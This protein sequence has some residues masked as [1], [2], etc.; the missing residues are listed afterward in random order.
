MMFTTRPHDIYAHVSKRGGATSEKDADDNNEWSQTLME[1]MNSKSSS[2]LSHVMRYYTCT[3]PR[4]HVQLHSLSLLTNTNNKQPYIHVMVALRSVLVAIMTSSAS[5][6]RAF[7]SHLTQQQQPALQS[8]VR[9]NIIKGSPT[10]RNHQALSSSTSEEDGTS[11]SATLPP[12]RRSFLFLAAVMAGGA[13]WQCDPLVTEAAQT[14]CFQDCL[15]NCKLIAPKVSWSP[16]AKENV[17]HREIFLPIFFIIS[18]SNFL[19]VMLFVTC[20]NK[21]LNWM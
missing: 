1:M 13:S 16:I 19:F 4:P 6:S 7:T 8:A 2:C 5:F 3:V 10:I 15:K 17:S 12:S 18:S 20:F 21:F 14:D 9:I 11:S